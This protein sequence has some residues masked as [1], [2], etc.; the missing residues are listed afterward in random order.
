MNQATD[1]QI[2][3][4]SLVRGKTLIFRDATVEDAE[5]ILNLR[6][7]EKKGR[8]LSATSDS[9]EVQQAWLR[10]YA[11][12]TGQAYFIIEREGQAIGTVRLYDARGN[13]FCWGSWIIADGQPAPVAMESALMVYAYA[14]DH[15]GFEQ[16]HFDVRAANEKVWKFHERFGAKLLR[17]VGD[18]FFYELSID[19]IRSS[20]ERYKRFLPHGITALP[21]KKS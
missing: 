9:L 17:Q 15:L 3:K 1:P 8:F 14:L 18:D 16:A 7:D 20:I 5:L 2:R 11:V 10:A 21:T 19:S 6:T 12:S 4:A 13:S